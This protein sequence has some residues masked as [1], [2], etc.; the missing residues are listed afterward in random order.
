MKFKELRK[1]VG[2]WDGARN[3]EDDEATNIIIY[4]KLAWACSNNYGGPTL[5][6]QMAGLHTENINLIVPLTD[7][8]LSALMF[9]F[10]KLTN[11]EW[12][13]GG[14]DYRRVKV[15]EFIREW[16]KK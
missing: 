5:P 12:L 6:S 2:G 7:E 16:V 4:D 13:S 1:I 15:A 9:V 14:H 10:P 3:R 11:K 8:L